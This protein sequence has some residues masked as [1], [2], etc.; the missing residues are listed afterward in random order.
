MLKTFSGFGTGLC[1]FFMVILCGYQGGRMAFMSWLAGRAER[2]GWHG[3]SVFLLGF[4]ASE[5]VYPLLFPWFTGA[6]MHKVP[7][8]MQAA[9]L[10]GPIMI[11][12]LLLGGSVA[13]AEPLIARWIDARPID[14]RVIGVGLA[15]PLLLAAYGAIRV[16]MIDKRNAAAQPAKIGVVQGDLPLISAKRPPKDTLLVHRSET[17]KLEENGPLDL[18]VWSETA[19]AFPIV[20]KLLEVTMRRMVQHGPT[21]PKVT[22]ANHFDYALKSPLLTGLVLR[23]GGFSRREGKLYNSAALF[24]PDGR[25]EGVYDK[26]Y[27]L[28]FGEYIPFGETF[29]VLYEMS[30]NSGQLVPGSSLEPIPFH[31]DGQTHKITTLICYEDILPSFTNAA[32]RHGDPDL[33]VNMTNDAWFGATTEPEIHFALSK[34]R[35][36]EHHRWLVRSTNSGVS[37]LVD[38]V[39]RATMTTPIFQQT[40]FAG[41]VRWMRGKT[42]Y[43]VLGDSIWWLCTAAVVAMAFVRKERVF[44]ARPA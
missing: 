21:D 37:A 18:V 7:T 43:E 24:E 10:G 16:P 20:D 5:L 6:Q 2:R 33:L 3:Y 42:V 4:I 35:A 36:V 15:G 31:H 22:R 34:L 25:A 41:E 44:K 17:A 38:P 30:P 8:L 11:G 23:R 26:T 39:G 19:I 29:P 14:R 27:L 1:L 13:A 40:S 32:V 28:A 9:D 12:V